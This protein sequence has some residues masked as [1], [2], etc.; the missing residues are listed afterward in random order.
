MQECPVRSTCRPPAQR[1][2]NPG[3][4]ADE[5]IEIKREGDKRGNFYYKFHIPFAVEELVE[6]REGG[7]LS[8][9]INFGK[10]SAWE[11]FCPLGV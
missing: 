6:Y 4:N 2:A 9:K 11:T 5:T 8:G 10:N 1:Q 7:I 3:V